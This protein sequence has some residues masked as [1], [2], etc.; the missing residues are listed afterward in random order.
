MP[1]PRLSSSISAPSAAISA[2]R[3]A[4]RAAA[5]SKPDASN[6]CDPMCECRPAKCRPAAARTRATAARASP[7]A[8]DRPNFWSSCAVAM[9]SCVCASTPTVTRTS[10]RAVTPWRW[11]TAETVSISGMAS[12]TRVPTPAA[13]ARSISATDLLLP[14]MMMRS[15]GNPAAR[16]TANSPPLA[17]SRPS[18]SSS[19][20]RAMVVARNAFA[21]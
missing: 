16:A 11:A 15:G 21:A 19:H 14:C 1:P 20:Q 5:I 13:S 8:S 12:M 9:N 2:A 10:T 17:T 4:M 6:I 3:S 7:V 18:P